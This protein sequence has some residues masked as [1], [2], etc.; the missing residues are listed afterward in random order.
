M[1]LKRAPLAHER[2]CPACLKRMG[3]PFGIET[4]GTDS[5]MVPWGLSE[6]D[7]LPVWD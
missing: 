2:K 7:G 6:E 4:T 5:L 1:G 3:F